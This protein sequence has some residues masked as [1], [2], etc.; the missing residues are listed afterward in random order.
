M[1]VQRRLSYRTFASRRCRGNGDE[2]LMTTARRAEK[3]EKDRNDRRIRTARTDRRAH[4]AGQHDGRAGILGDAAAGRRDDQRAHDERQGYARGTAARLFR[5]ARYRGAPVPQR[6]DRC[7][8]ARHHRRVLCRRHPARARRGRRA[9]QADRRAVHHRRACGG[10]RAQ[11]AQGAADRHRL[12]LSRG[13][14]QDLHS[15]L[16]GARLQGRRRRADRQ[17]SRSVPSD[18]FD[19]GGQCA[20]RGSTSSRTWASTPS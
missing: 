6:A 7:D 15:L 19:R 9:H 16:G 2:G 1:D 8:R 17:P 14:D 4:A 12:A 13:S 18:L 11:H 20:S 3:C 10:A 5:A